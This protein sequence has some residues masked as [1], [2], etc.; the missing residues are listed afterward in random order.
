MEP[1]K[2]GPLILGVAGAAAV[3]VMSVWAAHT[4]AA[5]NIVIRDI[6]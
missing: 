4:G 2:E 3:E 1:I 6:A 5:S